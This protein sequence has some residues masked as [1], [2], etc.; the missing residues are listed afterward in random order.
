M[1]NI[2]GKVVVITGASS[3]PSPNLQHVR[4]DYEPSTNHQFI[5]KGKGGNNVE[6]K[7]HFILGGNY[8]L[9]VWPYSKFGS[10]EYGCQNAGRHR[11]K[12]YVSK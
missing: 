12:S 6:S 8:S 7:K 2:E 4:S 5:Q 11:P 10:Q 3:G 1:S 9:I